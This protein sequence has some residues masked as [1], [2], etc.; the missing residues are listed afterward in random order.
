[1]NYLVIK[2]APLLALIVIRVGKLLAADGG[3]LFLD[4]IGNLPLHLQAKLL[5][6]LEQRKVT[7]VGENKAIPFD[8]RV[9]SA[10]NVNKAALSNEQQFRQDLLFRLNTVEVSLPPL[11]ERQ[12]DIIPIAEHYVSVYCKKYQKD[13]KTLSLATKERLLDE[14]WLGNVR[15]LRHAIERAVIMSSSNSLQPSDFQFT[16]AVQAQSQPISTPNI[17]QNPADSDLVQQPQEHAPQTLEQ[18]EKHAISQALRKHKYNISH[19]AKALGLTRAALYR[20]MEKH[21]L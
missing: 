19:S 4:E 10:T 14:P 15:A 12:D 16:P 7:P 20:R 5:T 18:I 6:V 1:M 21:G 17:Q 3:S 13:H 9:I 11:R 8:V 2:K